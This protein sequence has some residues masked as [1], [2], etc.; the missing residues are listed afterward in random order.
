MTVV[1]DSNEIRLEK[2]KEAVDAQ[3]LDHSLWFVDGTVAEAYLQQ[4]LR[5]LHRVIEDLNLKALEKIK[6]QSEEHR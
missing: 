3:A 2:I 1:K 6:E 5:W 4:S